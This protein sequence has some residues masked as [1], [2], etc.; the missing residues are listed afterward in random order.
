MEVY[1]DESRFES[2]SGGDGSLGAVVAEVQATVAK[3]D[4]VVVGI[5]CDGNDVTGEDYEAELQRRADGFERIELRSGK[6][7]DLVRDAVIEADRLLDDTEAMRGEIVS[8]LTVGDSRKSADMFC[9]C[10][11][12]WSKVNNAIIQSLAIL[13][14][15][16]AAFTVQGRPLHDVMSEVCNKL[17]QIKDALK[18]GDDV[19]LADALE[20]EFGPVIASWKAVLAAIAEQIA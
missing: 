1:V 13:G 8:H 14:Q 12:H 3:E 18:T 19:L 9:E 17:N 4:R 11:G 6:P 5:L 15:E 7:T 10:L 20:Y 16:H 2:V